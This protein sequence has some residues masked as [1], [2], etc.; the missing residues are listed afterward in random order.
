[1]N[2]IQQ[3]LRTERRTLHAADY[4]TKRRL[5]YLFQTLTI[6]SNPQSLKRAFD[7]VPHHF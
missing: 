6:Q 5:I 1:M 4:A 2:V 7:Y 3:N